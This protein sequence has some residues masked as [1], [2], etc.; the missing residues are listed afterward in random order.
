MHS[1]L[2]FLRY[3]CWILREW[4]QTD[5]GC[6]GGA[7]TLCSTEHSIFGVLIRRCGAHGR[8]HSSLWLA[9]EIDR[10][11]VFTVLWTLFARA[12]RSTDVAVSLL[13]SK[14]PQGALA[15]GRNMQKTCGQP[16]G[17]R[18]YQTSSA[19]LRSTQSTLCQIHGMRFIG[20]ARSA[21]SPILL[22]GREAVPHVRS[23]RT[24][25]TKVYTWLVR[26]EPRPLP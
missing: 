25:R 22:E 16:S 2:F 19:E 14:L 7:K 15:F 26:M 13:G 1:D 12:Q 6:H 23:G 10:I 11:T 4:Q 3:P 5:Y 18:V 24:A 9:P 20:K 21:C 17:D 8:S